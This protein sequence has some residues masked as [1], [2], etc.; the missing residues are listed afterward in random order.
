MILRKRIPFKPSM[1]FKDISLI[2]VLKISALIFLSWLFK[3]LTEKP[4]ITPQT[5]DQHFFSPAP[6]IQEKNHGI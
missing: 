3:T 5:F 6:L 2:L 4:R 1:L